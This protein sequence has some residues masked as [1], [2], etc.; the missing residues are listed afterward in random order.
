MNKFLSKTKSKKL[1]GLCCVFLVLVSISTCFVGCSV[2]NKIN[3]ISKNLTTYVVEAGF[4]EREMVVSGVMSVVFVNNTDQTLNELRFH[5]YP[6]AYREGAKN[7][8]ISPSK[9]NDA[10]P[11]G[12][13]YG[14]I[15]IEYTMQNGNQLP[16]RVKFK[17]NGISTKTAYKSNG[18]LE[19][20]AY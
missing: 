17:I 8:P 15:E 14:G 11:N 18:K 2:G 7:P 20:N 13:D 4:D 9:T 16:C 19:Q 12:H 6:N 3:K 10:D 1:L 5:L